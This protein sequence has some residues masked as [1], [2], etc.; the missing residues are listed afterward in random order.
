[1]DHSL[2]TKKTAPD[3]TNS[4]PLIRSKLHRS[5]ITTAF[6][7]RQRLLVLPEGWTSKWTWI[8]RPGIA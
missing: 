1:M 6:V 5:R 3:V 4:Q 7:L 8:E 2:L